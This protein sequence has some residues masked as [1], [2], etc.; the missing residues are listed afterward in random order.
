MDYACAQG[1][2]SEGSNQWRV[3][4]AL[5]IV[6]AAGLS[7]GMI[8]LRE[9]PRWLARNGRHEEA[10]RNL[11]YIRHDEDSNPSQE[12]RDEYA[13][14][15]DSTESELLEAGTFKLK[16]LWLPRYRKRVAIGL[17]VMVGQQ[18][19]GTTVFTYVS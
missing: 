19:S 17:A 6:P 15:R 8:P 16:E 13:Q 4:V 10:L 5:Q 14:I 2:S 1:F 7:L 12:T 3:P 9:S 11:A 18:L